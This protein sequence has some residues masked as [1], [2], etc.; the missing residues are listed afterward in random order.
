MLDAFAARHLEHVID[1]FFVITNGERILVVSTTFAR[2]AFDPD[3]G[4]K[5]H[6]DTNLPVSKTF[7]AATARQH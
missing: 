5:M 2:F 4:Q 7:F 3:V 6:L 1:R